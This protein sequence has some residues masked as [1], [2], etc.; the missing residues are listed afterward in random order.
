MLILT[1]FLQLSDV[2]GGATVFPNVGRFVYPTKGS[3]LLWYNV[4]SDGNRN[5]ETLHGSCPVLRGTKI[6]KC[7]CIS[8]S[9]VIKVI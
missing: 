5:K 8:E 1:T 6:S 9:V 4:H 7:Q 2:D 3:M